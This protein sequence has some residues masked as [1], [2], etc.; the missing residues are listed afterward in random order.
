MFF[1]RGVGRNILFLIYHNTKIG[2]LS[3]F[4]N[5][6]FYNDLFIRFIRILKKICKVWDLNPRVLS[7]NDLKSLPLDR[8]GNL[9][10]NIL[11][12]LIDYIIILK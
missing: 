5:I 10:T 3:L 7:T 12:I 11:I 1:Q 8:S 4:I 2:I 6:I 9:A